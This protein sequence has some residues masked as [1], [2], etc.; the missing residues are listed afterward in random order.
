MFDA[1]Q[2]IRSYTDFHNKI[3]EKMMSILN[4]HQIDYD[5]I[6]DRQIKTA[7]DSSKK[8]LIIFTADVLIDMSSTESVGTNVEKYFKILE[9]F[10]RPVVWITAVENAA[11]DFE[12][13]PNNVQFLH[14]GG[15]FLMQMIEYPQV[16]PQREKNQTAEKFWIS[17]SNDAARPARIMAACC[18]LGHNLGHN[19]GTVNGLLRISS[20]P[21]EPFQTWQELYCNW[22]KD[23]P[24]VS[25]SQCDLLQNGFL[26]MKNLDHGGQ[27]AGSIYEGLHGFDNAGNF[28]RSLRYLYS[29]SRIEI[30]NE[31]AFFAKGIFVTE[32]FLNS[33]Y[34]Y[35]LPIVLSTPGTVDY[36]R[37]HGF[38]MFDDV[39]DHSYDSICDPLQRIFAAIESNIQLLSDEEHAVKT[40]SKCLHRLDQNYQFASENM[41]N[42]FIDHFTSTFTN[43]LLTN[44]IK[45]H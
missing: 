7:T 5:I 43:Y 35:N 8:L 2:H 40:W 16:K 28:D 20:Y 23:V 30:V 17:L 21:L 4:H 13:I 33:V 41:Y 15:D 12:N 39:I 25:N 26:N 22:V 6:S 9:K 1:K 44:K 36:L 11:C 31:T 24:V 19:Y 38:D 27:P 14:Y 10:D 18:L 32:K 3:I 45:T 34:G 42:H 29:D 37:Q